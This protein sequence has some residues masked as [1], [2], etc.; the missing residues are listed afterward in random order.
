MSYAELIAATINYAWSA[1]KAFISISIVMFCGSIIW[2]FL[3]KKADDPIIRLVKTT[4]I[5]GGLFISLMIFIII[6][7]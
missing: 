6:L 5:I 3:P 4:G 2:C 1:F 7:R